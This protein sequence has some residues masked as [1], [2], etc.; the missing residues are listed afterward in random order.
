MARVGTDVE[1]R[2]RDVLIDVGGTRWTDAELVRWINDAQIKIVVNKPTA[3]VVVGSSGVLTAGTQQAL[4]AGGLQ[5]L[6]ALHN[7][8]SGAV[9]R[10]AK[11]DDLDMENPTWHASTLS[12]VDVEHFIVDEATPDIYWVYPY[13]DGTGDIEIMY[14]AVTTDLTTLADSIDLGDAY[15]DIIVDY[16]LY[17]CALKDSDHPNSLQRANIHLAAF[18]AAVGIEQ[19]QIIET[20]FSP[21][22]GNP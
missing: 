9:V 14:S 3:K 15:L 20:V 4:P 6:N 1:D 19:K 8:V 13:N 18:N 5:L 17:R 7:T 12:Q 21:N 10:L 11:R 22:Q 2:A 16:V